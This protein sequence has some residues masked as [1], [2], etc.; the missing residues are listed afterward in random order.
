MTWAERNPHVHLHFTPA[1]ISWIN[2]IEAWFG[3]ITR[4]CIRCGTYLGCSLVR[5]FQASIKNS[6][7]NNA[8]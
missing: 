8:E 6:S 5:L 7:T 2:Q 4:Q 3:I 1:G